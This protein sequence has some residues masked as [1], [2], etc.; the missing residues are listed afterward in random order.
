[1]TR[2]YTSETKITSLVLCLFR[3][4]TL[5][6]T[7]SSATLPCYSNHN[8]NGFLPHWIKALLFILKYVLDFAK[9]RH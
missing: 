1:M 8:T 4:V 2:N 5:T 3:Y 7:N 6:Y 9:P